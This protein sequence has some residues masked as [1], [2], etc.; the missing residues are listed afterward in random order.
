MSNADGIGFTAN[1]S[2]EPEAGWFVWCVEHGLP[3]R[4]VFV[5]SMEECGSVADAL[6]AAM[7]IVR[8]G[9]ISKR[10]YSGGAER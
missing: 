8:H 1:P 3:P 7:E 9:K 5:G 10:I 4:P 2:E 6:N